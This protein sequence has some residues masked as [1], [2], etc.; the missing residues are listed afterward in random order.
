KSAPGQL[1]AYAVDRREGN[2]VPGTQV[3]IWA[4]HKKLTSAQTDRDG[5][6]M[7]SLSTDKAQDVRILGRHG[8]DLA[9]VAPYYLNIS[10]DPSQDWIGY[11]YTDRPVYRP[12]H[13][14][15]FRAVLRTR[16]GE[17][18]RVPSGQQVRLTVQDNSG[19]Q[20]YQSSAALS[21]FGTVH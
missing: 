3:E 16:D 11:V 5:L 12:G 21:Q 1:L 13:P 20:V 10:S 18:Y 4:A 2:P 6:S 15:H 9:L 7:I 17:K 8:S 14:V 19:K